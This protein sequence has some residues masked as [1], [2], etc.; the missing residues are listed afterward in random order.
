MKTH[1]LKT[2]TDKINIK[3]LPGYEINKKLINL[4]D[5]FVGSNKPFIKTDQ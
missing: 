3:P 1:K 2:S 4:I 5:E